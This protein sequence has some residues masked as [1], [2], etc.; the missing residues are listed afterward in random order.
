MLLGNLKG[1]ALTLMLAVLLPGCGVD[2]QDGVGPRVP[3][4]NVQGVAVRATSPAQGLHV[5]LRTDAGQE[6]ATTTTTRWGSFGF[7]DVGPGAWEIK[8]AGGGPGDFE[9]VT[10]GFQLGPDPAPLS[11]PPVDVLAYGAAAVEPA[12]GATLTAPSLI[13]PLVFRWTRPDL[14]GVTARVQLYDA[15]GSPVWFSS[16]LQADQVPWNGLGNQGDYQ[17]QPVS[18]GQYTWRVKFV[19]PDAAEGRIA[20]RR[21]SL[22]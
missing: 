12:D 19:L 14:P 13:E 20:S 16:A 11:L 10:R 2:V 5:D 22:T 8:V 21:L 18:P 15:A 4:P 9:S 17:G 1:T 6:V 7:A 3:V